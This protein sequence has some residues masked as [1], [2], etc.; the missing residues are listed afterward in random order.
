MPHRLPASVFLLTLAPVLGAQANVQLRSLVTHNGSP[1]YSGV[2]GYVD[3]ATGRE[4][5]LVGAQDGAWIVETTDPVVPIERA[6]FPG[7]ITQWRELACY[8]SY[9]YVVSEATP[10]V[11][12]ISMV[13]PDQPALVGNFTIPNWTGTHTVSI[14]ITRGQL[15]CNGSSINRGLK[16]LDVATNPASP[17]LI[18]NLFPGLYV[19]DTFAQN[20]YAYLSAI[21]NGQL[22]IV[23]VSNLPQAGPL[24]GVVTPGA[25]THNAWANSTDTLALTTDEFNQGYLQLYDIS[26]KSAPV[27]LGSYSTSGAVS[28]HNVVL[29]DDKVAHLSYYEAGYRAVDVSDPSHPVE[30]GYYVGTSMW[31]VY[32]LQPSRNIYT[33]GIPAAGGLYI[34]HLACG[35]PEPYGHGTAGSGNFVPEIDW[36]GGHARVGNSTFRIEGRKL[37]G[38]TPTFILLGAAPA[39]LNVL[40]IQ[41]YIDATLPMLVAAQLS[42]GTLAG[43]GTA[44]QLLPLPNDP[45]LSGATLYAQWL[46]YDINASQG[47]SASPGLNITLCQ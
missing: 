37:L 3:Q 10:G 39:D 27:P 17:T 12:I 21:F 41:L 42:T 43:E 23:D 13:N 8:G 14:D 30:I 7:P 47:L 28:V 36:S 25:F 33:T 24:G 44:S 31:G 32:P 22:I 38:A 15:Y 6:F 1:G 18:A 26:N 46:A 5:A 45:A 35:V 16:I 20:G 2:W 40:G 19:H 34:L 29:R 9:V 11:D 4:F